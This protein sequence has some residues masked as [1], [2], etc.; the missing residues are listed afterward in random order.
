MEEVGIKY[1]IIYVQNL[2]LFMISG[3]FPGAYVDVSQFNHWIQGSV[4]SDLAHEDIPR[5]SVSPNE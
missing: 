5:P 2:I 4:S 1:I 3:N